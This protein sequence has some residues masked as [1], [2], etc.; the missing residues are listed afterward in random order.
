MLFS[1]WHDMSFM[2]QAARF[3]LAHGRFG[4]PVPYQLG[5]TCF[6]T[7]AGPVTSGESSGIDLP[8]LCLRV[9]GLQY[10]GFLA[11][12]LVLTVPSTAVVRFV[13][14]GADFRLTGPYPPYSVPD[15]PPY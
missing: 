8:C 14:A 9:G 6:E 5:Y 15:Y 7:G 12:F 3:E 13:V 1:V 2:E 11:P 4:K 10:H